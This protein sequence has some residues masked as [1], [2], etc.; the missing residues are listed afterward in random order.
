[1]LVAIYA[2][3]WSVDP[4]WIVVTQGLGHA[5]GMILDTYTDLGDG[6]CFFTPVY[7]EFRAKTEKGERRPVEI[8]MAREGIATCWISTPPRPDG[9][10]MKV[11]IFCAPQNPSGRVWTAD[12]MA[13]S[14]SSPRATT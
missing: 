13:P 3:G 11:L 9:R 2:H 5:I 12:E 4:D 10:P 7:H 6:V 1:V 14:R 8:P